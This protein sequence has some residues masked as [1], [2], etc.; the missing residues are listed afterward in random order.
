VTEWF[1]DGRGDD[2]HWG[3]ALH[4]ARNNSPVAPELIR[5]VLEDEKTPSIVRATALAE[6]TPFLDR[7]NS[8]LLSRSFT[9]SDPLVRRQ[10]VLALDGLPLEQTYGILLDL[11]G[12]SSRIVRTVAAELLSPIQR[13]LSADP[14]GAGLQLSRVLAEYIS[15]QEI[16]GDRPESH[17]NLG[18]LASR[19]GDLKE[20]V[21][22]YK[23]A[24]KRT[25]SFGPASVNLADALRAL[26]RDPEGI[27]VLQQAIDRV[28]DDAGLHHA[29]GLAL[30]RVG[31][32]E[33][34]LQSLGQAVTL[35]PQ[36]PRY[37][38]V[39]AVALEDGGQ[40]V[41]A[42]AALEKALQLHPS[43]RWLLAAKQ[44]YIDKEKQEFIDKEE[45]SISPVPATPEKKAGD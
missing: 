26:D 27:E 22:C 41:L 34:A 7:T 15:M 32:K 2:F 17:V 28:P 45:S 1:P 16:N 21:R 13:E 8:D 12:D 35:A 5:M 42:I 9:D 24:L 40:R 37:A 4:A 6:L 39:H 11:L 3:E 18:A 30:V 44:E 43:D 38:L 19:R 33:Q 23:E 25:P 31:K 14:Q 20:A 10:A 36:S 29:L